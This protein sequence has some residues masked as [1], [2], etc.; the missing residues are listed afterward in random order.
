M[1]EE[2]LTKTEAV[3]RLISLAREV[4]IKDPVDWS[5]IKVTEQQVYETMASSA[6]DQIY[7]LPE[8]HRQSV[9]MATITK[10]LVENFVLT[11]NLS[12]ERSKN[13]TSSNSS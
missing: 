7:S 13:A 1:T 6:I 4:E 3:G 8:D 5:S 11:Q 9:A 2:N 12:I 10:L